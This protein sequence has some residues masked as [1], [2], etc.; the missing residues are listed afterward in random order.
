[1]ESGGQDSTDNEKEMIAPAPPPTPHPPTPFSSHPSP[2][3]RNR[4]KKDRQFTS[5]RRPRAGTESLK[6]E[7]MESPIGRQRAQTGRQSRRVVC[8]RDLKEARLKTEPSRCKIEPSRCE[9]K[10][11]ERDKTEDRA[12]T[13]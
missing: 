9:T 2:Q 8:P 3:N 12:V 10:G 1:M 11:I 5:E 4:L 13:L 7:I 6:G